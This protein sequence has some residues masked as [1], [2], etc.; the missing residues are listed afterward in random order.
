MSTD[1]LDSGR[2]QQKQRTRDQLIAAARE[3]ISSG[4]TP[5][6]EEVAKAAGIS[7]PT[8]YRY[9]ASQ[10]EL[11]AAAFPETATT[12]ALPDP[13]PEAVDD[14]VAAV[15]AFVI[16]RVQDTEPQQRAML[17][18]SLGEVPHELPLRQGRVIP[19]FVE[20]LEPLEESIGEESVHRLALALRAACGIE[21]RVWLSDVAGL[22]P[23]DVSALQQWMVDA[24]VKQAFE[25]PPP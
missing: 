22:A 10:A 19:W 6:V 21:T 20:A 25:T 14:R 8:A 1:Y 12:S 4:E 5:R 11:L 24:L 18:L 2:A 17:R 9:F 7:R 23:A 13:P 15:A 3:L 16:G